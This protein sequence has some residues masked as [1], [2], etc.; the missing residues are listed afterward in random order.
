MERGTLS[1]AD[2]SQGR[3]APPYHSKLRRLRAR[4]TNGGYGWRA[5]KSRA[6]AMVQP[7]HAAVGT[8]LTIRILGKDH[9]ATI[10]PE[11]PY[12]PANARL[13]A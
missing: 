6:L 11:S 8:D 4:A 2:Q 5:G 13:R 12:D 10:I 3:G 9:Q 7:D 1:K